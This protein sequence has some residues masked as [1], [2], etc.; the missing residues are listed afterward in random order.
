M[1]KQVPTKI[2]YPSAICVLSSDDVVIGSDEGELGIFN[3][4]EGC[5]VK[6][7]AKRNENRRMRA[8]LELANGLLL[9][10]DND[11]GSI[12][13]RRMETDNILRVCNPMSGQVIQSFK[14]HSQLISSMRLSKDQTTLVT[15]AQD[16][17][18]KLWKI[19]C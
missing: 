17:T 19:N 5:L 1:V 14:I 8:I 16:R 6:K 13:A 10:A 4:L 9:V 11:S 3:I 18:I 2:K 12:S 7:L 15:S